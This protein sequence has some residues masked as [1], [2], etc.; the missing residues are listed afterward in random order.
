MLLLILTLI[1]TNNT[2]IDGVDVTNSILRT[3]MGSL[4]RVMKDTIYRE[5]L[6]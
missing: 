3:S 1:A 2:S 4:F 5:R 6:L